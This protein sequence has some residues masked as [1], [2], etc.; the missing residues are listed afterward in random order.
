MHVT[1][2]IISLPSNDRYPILYNSKD[3]FQLILWLLG[4]GQQNQRYLY[5]FLQGLLLTTLVVTH[6]KDENSDIVS[7]WMS[8]YVA[9]AL[10]LDVLEE[11]TQLDIKDIDSSS[12][13]LP[14]T[15]PLR[16]IRNKVKRRNNVI[17]ST[18][19]QHHTTRPRG[20]QRDG[21]AP[22]NH[23][24]NPQSRQRRIEVNHT[25]VVRNCQIIPSRN[26][27]SET[28]LIQEAKYHFRKALLTDNYPQAKRHYMI[29]KSICNQL[30][31]TGDVSVCYWSLGEIAF[32]KCYYSQATKFYGKTIE[33]YDFSQMF[34]KYQRSL[35]VVHAQFSN[36][37]CQS[38]TT[39]KE[40]H[41][42][43][44]NIA[45]I[46]RIITSTIANCTTPDIDYSSHIEWPAGVPSVDVPQASTVELVL[47]V[48]LNSQGKFNGFEV[49]EEE[50][51]Y[52]VDY[53]LCDDAMMQPTN[54]E[55]EE[56]ELPAITR[57]FYEIL[58][59]V[60]VKHNN[61]LV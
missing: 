52:E 25:N 31:R 45:D 12:E 21:V 53:V 36:A 1:P 27:K 14:K 38:K 43:V 19:H 13:V 16:K 8:H 59:D 9:C 24:P 61:I 49:A 20:N 42:Q 51:S 46:Q 47:S 30:N 40:S 33:T 57:P 44:V 58:G 23:P 32:E 39:A 29:C 56:G 34:D 54:E 48:I 50:Q 17:S 7:Q 11:C 26:R 6:Y 28:T 37:I 55:L 22:P 10:F 60:N 15:L 3:F 41:I 2:F 18:S 4:N 5:I 35:S